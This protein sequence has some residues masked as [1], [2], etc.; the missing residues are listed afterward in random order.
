MQQQKDKL[1]HIE[2]KLDE[3]LE[4]MEML[5]NMIGQIYDNSPIWSGN[6]AY[7]EEYPGKPVILTDRE[8]AKVKELLK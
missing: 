6:I 1:W 3:C 7:T 2:R 4:R 8:E 5:Q